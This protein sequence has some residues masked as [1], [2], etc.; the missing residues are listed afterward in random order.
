MKSLLF[1]GASGF[2]GKNI[3]PLLSKQYYIKTLGLT[4]LDDYIVDLSNESPHLAERYDVVLHAAGKA[5]KEP[6]TEVEKRDFFSVNLKG[7]Q[8]LCVALEKV[9]APESL[10]FI[11]SV[12]VYGLD[13][14]E[15][16]T[17]EQPLNGNTPYAES[18]IQAE[19]YLTEWCKK[20]KVKL[21]IIRPS[22]IAGPNPPGNLENMIKGI[23]SGKYLSI[24][25]GNAR[26]SI[27]MVQDIASLIPLIVKRGGIFNVC[28][29]EQPTFREIEKLISAQ[30]GKPTPVS[31]PY[32]IAKKIAFFGDFL[33][34]L[35]PINTLKLN[36]MTKSLTFSN[37]KAK[38][39]LGWDPL[40]VLQNFKINSESQ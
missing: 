5:H 23:K 8:N 28:D 11:S 20:N 25:G 4:P 19:E 9:G 3:K 35:S 16:I 21:G 29:S 17:E 10:L 14:G 18:K 13:F 1:T 38:R 24:G 15:N 12:A 40:N 2:L 34:K 7:T 36:K 31:I 6:K 22:L 32:F 26:K 33:G 39:E 30:L 27:I 37:E